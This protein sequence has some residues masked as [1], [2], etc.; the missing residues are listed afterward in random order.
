VPSHRDAAVLVAL[1]GALGS[2]GRWGVGELL[3]GSWATLAVN[4]VGC[5]AIG[6]LAG[7]VEHTRPR[8]RLLVGVGFLGGF[9]T[10]SSFLLET[11]S[12]AG[13]PAAA[14]GV[15]TVLGCVV[16]AALGVRVGRRAR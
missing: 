4:L 3:P 5:L 1:G 14:Y 12:L 11:S 2:L 13:V 15:A 10:F 6:L 9:T 8:L 7:R 16:L